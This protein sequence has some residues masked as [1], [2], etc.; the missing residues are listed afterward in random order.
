MNL[1]ASPGKTFDG[2]T[3]WILSYVALDFVDYQKNVLAVL[4]DDSLY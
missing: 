1:C 2:G 4:Q 3:I